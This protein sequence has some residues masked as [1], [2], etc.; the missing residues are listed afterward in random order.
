MTKNWKKIT[1]EK[2]FN[3]FISK[4]AIYLSTALHKERS[5]YRR[6]LQLFK[7][8]TFKFYFY[9]CGSFLPSWIRIRIRNP[10]LKYLR[11]V[12]GGVVLVEKRRHITESPEQLV[13][14]GTATTV[15]SE[16]K[17]ILRF[18]KV[19]LNKQ[20]KTTL[21]SFCFSKYISIGFNKFFFNFTLIT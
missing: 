17:L 14:F 20:P 7:T 21:F 18:Y 16:S 3:F 11:G 19:A 13:S 10:N 8:W 6:S 4:T 15:L 9:F 2:K 5:S 1:A 12:A